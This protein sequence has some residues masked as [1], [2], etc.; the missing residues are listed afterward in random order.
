MRRTRLETVVKD[1]TC[2]NTRCRKRFRPTYSTL[3]KACSPLCAI[4]VVNASKAAL[5]KADRARTREQREGLRTHGQWE[6]LIQDVINACARGLDEGRPCTSCGLPAKKPQGGHYH[7]VGSNN[8]IRFNLDN[9]HLQCFPCNHHLSGNQQ[10]Y[11]L[12]LERRYGRHY[13]EYVSQGMVLRYPSLNLSIPELREL[14]KEARILLT[15]IRSGYIKDRVNANLF[16][17]IYT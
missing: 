4:A 5:E 16:L 10:G 2:A 17:K 15:L 6:N 3:Q 8:S 14:L 1:R 13:A 11:L 9:I 12:G 7:S